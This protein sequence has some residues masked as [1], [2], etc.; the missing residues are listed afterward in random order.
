LQIASIA[1]A[2]WFNKVRLLSVRKLLGFNGIS[3]PSYKSAENL[4][5]TDSK[6]PAHVVFVSHR[7]RTTGNPDP[8]G[9]N[10]TELKGLLGSVVLL[11]RGLDPNDPTPAPSLGE[12]HMLHAS[13][14]LWRLIQNCELDAEEIL[15]RFAVFFDYSCLPQNTT[16]EQCTLLRNGLLAFLS[17]IPDTSVSLVALR[18]VDDSYSKRA[19]CVAES[20]LSLSYSDDRQWAETFPLRICVD[21]QDTKIEFEP[22][23]NAIRN[24][25]KTTALKPKITAEQFHNWL[26]IVQLCVDWHEQS[27]LEATDKFHHSISIADQSF[28]LWTRITIRISERGETTVDLIP[29]LI[30]ALES[31][32]L[33]CTNP[34]DLVFTALIILSSLRWEE[35]NRTSEQLNVGENIQSD[36]WR[37]CLLQYM[38]TRSIFARVYP[39]SAK[40]IGQLT[41]PR[42]EL[43]GN[44]RQ[45]SV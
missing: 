15:D 3:L 19:W 36:F 8:D 10:F 4:R 31:E 2:E 45:S 28:K 43:V 16:S 12:R 42:L 6:K 38:D 37:R 21:R 7:W 29:E 26:D 44:P 23:A 25:D 24:W 5:W 30:S 27:R 35:L 13:V 41:P 17:M 34:N 22:L 32:D 33:R 40:A 11:A 20:V 9:R 14:L 39:Q 18:H 1:E